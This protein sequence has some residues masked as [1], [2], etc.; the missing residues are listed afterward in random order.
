MLY[1]KL[2]ISDQYKIYGLVWLA[3][4][5]RVER[6]EHST[7]THKVIM[8]LVRFNYIKMSKVLSSLVKRLKGI[9]KTNRPVNL[10]GKIPK[11]ILKKWNAE[12]NN[13]S[14]INIKYFLAIF[15]VNLFTSICCIA[16]VHFS[17]LWFLEDL[18]VLRPKYIFIVV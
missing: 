4:L 17:G 14:G 13:L 2:A 3:E 5:V 8:K 7:A 16:Y 12:S 9:C 10:V 15:S 11:R 18:F 1:E 6:K